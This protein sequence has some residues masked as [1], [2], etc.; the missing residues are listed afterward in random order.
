VDQG[1]VGVGLHALEDLVV[2][3]RRPA[4]HECGAQ[5]VEQAGR[6]G[7]VD[8]H[9]DP[10]RDR[11]SARGGE[12]AVRP[13]VVGDGTALLGEEV[14]RGCRRCSPSGW[15]GGWLWRLGRSHPKN[16]SAGRWRASVSYR[17]VGPVPERVPGPLR[18]AAS[19]PSA[20]A[21]TAKGNSPGVAV[22]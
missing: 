21:S 14:E 17:S 9:A 20:R 12:H 15:T 8:R 3:A 18:A 7:I 2:A 11:R 19:P 6:K 13:E 5:V 1:E 10:A 16:G 4:E 22:T